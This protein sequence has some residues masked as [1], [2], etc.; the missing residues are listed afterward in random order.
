MCRD[1]SIRQLRQKAD[2]LERAKVAAERRLTNDL[3]AERRAAATLRQ[4]MKAMQVRRCGCGGCN[5]GLC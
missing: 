4:Q 2:V 3:A 5:S 1:E